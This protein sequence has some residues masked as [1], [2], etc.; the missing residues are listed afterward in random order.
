MIPHWDALGRF[1]G[2][3]SVLILLGVGPVAAQFPPPPG[4]GG[5]ATANPFPPPPGQQGSANPFPPPPGSG[6][7]PAPQ[8]TSADPF[9]P[10]GG[11]PGPARSAAPSGG[12]PFPAP[13][14]MAPQGQNPCEAF[15]PIRAEAEKGAAAIRSAGE[16]KAARE[17]VCGLFRT[18]A[19]SEA[20]MVRFL[21]A[22]QKTC[23]VPADAVKQAKAQH[24]QTLKIRTQVCSAGPAPGPRAP[25]LSDAFGS[26]PLP[27]EPK[28]G[29]GTFDTLT[30]NALGR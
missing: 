21:E 7:A 15:L 10:V 14:A 20:K 22:N 25:Q 3:A 9:P 4:P 23:N 13:G 2:G 30:G 26:A 12:S 27:E 24:A 6:A 8:A 19:A 18:F 11:Q 28:R 1:V 5:A 29:H 16:R 17:Q